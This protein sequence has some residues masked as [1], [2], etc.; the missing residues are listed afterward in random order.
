RPEPRLT[1][2]LDGRSDLR[3]AFIA[4]WVLALEARLETPVGDGWARLLAP[5]GL[6]LQAPLAR[7]AALAA[8]RAGRLA[9]AH[10]ALRMEVG[11]TRI[12]RTELAHLAPEGVLLF[13]RFGPR[14]P[15][16]GPMS[17]CLGAGSFPARLGSDGLTLLG[18]FQLGA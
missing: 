17:L 12:A 14:P 15:F 5:E 2:E 11:W 6:E 9:E 3:Q 7:P 4:P 13:D 8:R 1:V 18:P 10:V 16:G